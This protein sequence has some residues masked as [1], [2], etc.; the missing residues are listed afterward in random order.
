MKWAVA[1]VQRYTSAADKKQENKK[2]RDLHTHRRVHK[3]GKKGSNSN[4]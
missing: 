3:H 1:E 4:G 2:H